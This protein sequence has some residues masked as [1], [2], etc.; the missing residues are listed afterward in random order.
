MD[1]ANSTRKRKVARYLD[2]VLFIA[3]LLLVSSLLEI[4]RF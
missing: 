3:A 1:I 2:A 4:I